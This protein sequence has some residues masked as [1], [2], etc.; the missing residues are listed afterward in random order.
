MTD[1]PVGGH[2]IGTIRLTCALPLQTPPGQRPVA[3]AELLCG[4]LQTIL[5]SDMPR[6]MSKL[7]DRLAPADGSTLRLD[8]VTVNLGAIRPESLMRALA[9][10]LPAALRNAGPYPDNQTQARG[11]TLYIDN[12]GLSLLIPFLPAAMRDAGLLNQD[13]DFPD[14]RARAVAILLLAEATGESTIPP[15]GLVTDP[16]ALNKILCGWPEEIPWTGE[17]LPEAACK[18]A[19]RILHTVAAHWKAMAGLDAQSLRREFLQRRGVLKRAPYPVLHVEKKTQDTLLND[20]PWVLSIIR[21][22]WMDAP[23]KVAWNE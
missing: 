20:L 1:F 2:R 11:D 13:G 22:P 12:A 6:L 4:E 15:S 17:K 19:D 14:H 18:A 9:D 5:R 10:K 8:R 3:D 21:T 23:M 16:L 7:M